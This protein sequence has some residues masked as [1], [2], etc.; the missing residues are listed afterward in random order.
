MIFN[1][2]IFFRVNA[3]F[4]SLL[5]FCESTFQWIAYQKIDGS[6][7]AIPSFIG[8]TTAPSKQKNKYRS[9][10]SYIH[11][12]LIIYLTKTT[13]QDNTLGIVFYN[14]F[15]WCIVSLSSILVFFLI[16]VKEGYILEIKMLIKYSLLQFIYLCKQIAI[17][18]RLVL[19][20][21]CDE[22]NV[23]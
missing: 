15:L 6:F 21:T 14:I 9:D 1:A 17:N 23:F 7:S 3:R 22:C 10:D 4:C 18:S 16:S 2:L 13:T 12:Y 20:T 11:Y 5:M 8:S 19:A